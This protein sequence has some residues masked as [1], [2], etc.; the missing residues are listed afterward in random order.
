MT[1]QQVTDL[2][3][4][5]LPVLGTVLTAWGVS[6]DKW[7]SISNLLLLIA[8]PGMIVVSAIWGFIR[9][10]KAG[11]VTAAAQVP[12]VKN[13]TLTSTAPESQSINA[14]TPSNVTIAH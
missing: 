13:I 2:L 14:Q 6:A 10:T 4:Q 12:E 8:G 3:R 7:T 5:L 9:N 1:P 11:L